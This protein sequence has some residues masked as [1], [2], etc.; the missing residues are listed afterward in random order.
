MG[1]VTGW[2]QGWHFALLA[3]RT[4]LLILTFGFIG[5]DI[6]CRSCRWQVQ[7]QPQ[8]P[9]QGLSMNFRTARGSDEAGEV[10]VD[11]RGEKPA[12]RGQEAAAAGGPVL[13]APAGEKRV[14]MGSKGRMGPSKVTGELPEFSPIRPRLSPPD[15]NR[16]ARKKL[17]SVPAR[18][19]AGSGGRRGANSEAGRVARSALLGRRRN[20][21]NDRRRRPSRKPRGAPAERDAQLES[22][23]RAAPEQLLA[24]ATRFRQEE[25]KLTSTTFALTGDSAH[26]QAM[27]HWSGHNSSVI[28]ILTKLYDYNLGSITESSLWRSTDYGTTYEKMNDK[29]GLKTILSYLYVC[30]TNKRK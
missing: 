5:A 16:P 21:Q 29:V 13:A 19:P 18:F 17:A 23:A 27:V 30:P 11:K 14:G 10:P 1:K 15:V 24:K 9:A 2:Y 20:N 7:L 3:A 8:Q 22:R 12:D 6:T 26:N 4:W 28:L 25:L